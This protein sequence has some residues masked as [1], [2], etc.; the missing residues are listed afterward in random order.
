M[1]ANRFESSKARNP[2][3]LVM[4]IETLETHDHVTNLLPA[5]NC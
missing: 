5:S 4:V 2:G 1:H 3:Q